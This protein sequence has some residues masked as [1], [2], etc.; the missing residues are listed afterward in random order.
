MERIGVE[1]FDGTRFRRPGTWAIA[2]SADWCGFC[3]DFAPKFATLGDPGG[4]QVAVADLTDE[5]SPLWER[6]EVDVVPT[7]IVFRAGARSFRRDGRLGRGLGVEDL[8][9]VRAALSRA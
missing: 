3:R 2:F 6:F 1:E 8:E 4:F 7:V 5:E 9:A